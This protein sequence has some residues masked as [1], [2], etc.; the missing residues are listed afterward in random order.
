VWNG[1]LES[2]VSDPTNCP[3]S[4]QR[5]PLSCASLHTS[6]Y[7]IVFPEFDA[8]KE[9]KRVQI[10]SLCSRGDLVT[11]FSLAPTAY[12]C[13]RLSSSPIRGQR[14]PEIIRAEA[15]PQ[16]LAVVFSWHDKKIDLRRYLS[17]LELCPSVFPPTGLCMLHA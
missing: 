4:R 5:Y 14:W 13:A 8:F 11:R 15:D 1:F 6:V 12:L 16:W 9:R 17:N 7:K 10:Y 3:Q 2:L